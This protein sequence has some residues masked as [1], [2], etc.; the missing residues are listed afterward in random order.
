[1]EV[2]TSAMDKGMSQLSSLDAIVG[3]LSGGVDILTA[4][5]KQATDKSIAQMVTAVVGAI[6]AA[7]GITH[8][9]M[10][11]IMGIVG[12][13][14]NQ[15][16]QPGFDPS[17]IPGDL[18]SVIKEIPEYF[19]FVQ[20]LMGGALGEIQ[21]DCEKKLDELFNQL[22]N[23]QVSSIATAVMARDASA[24]IDPITLEQQIDA[25]I[26]KCLHVNIMSISKQIEE[27]QKKIQMIKKVIM[28]KAKAICKKLKSLEV[29]D[30]SICPPAEFIQILDVLTEAQFIMSNLPVVIDKIWNFILN[31][32]VEMFTK[33]AD[34]IASKVI[35][36]IKTI[37]D[38]AKQLIGTLKD[39]TGM[40]GLS[41]PEPLATLVDVLI[42]IPEILWIIPNQAD[43][44]FN[45]AAN[46]A[47]PQMYDMIKP[48]LMAPINAVTTIT[49]T[50]DTIN[51]AKEL[52]DALPV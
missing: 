17:L 2:V 36:I 41:L 52:E 18:M 11:A 35:D 15:G 28:L 10:S 3:K 51:I 5:M 39:I 32:F 49:T 19:D 8:P 29:P 38:A 12:E 7:Y 30:V 22:E 47:L 14:E 26:K 27:I 24:P 20:K 50:M 48:Y 46:V 40:L 42:Q 37:L 16:Y 21:K 33:I 1:M 31:M 23:A 44:F 43:Y 9:M 25:Q 13:K 45:C 4:S 6:Q 34:E